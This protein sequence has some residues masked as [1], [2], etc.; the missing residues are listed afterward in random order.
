MPEFTASGLVRHGFGF[1]NPNHAAAL[2][3]ALAPFCWGWRGMWRWCGYAAFT[4]LCAALALTYSRAGMAVLAAE[5]AAWAVMKWRGSTRDKDGVLG[6]TRP[7]SHIAASALAVAAIVAAAWWMRSRIAV[8]GAVQNR[9]RIWLAGLRLFAANPLGVGFGYSGKIAS[10]FL[11][12]DGMTVRTLVNSHLTLLAETGVFVGGAW[13]VFVAA[14]I[15]A[16]W[17]RF[18]RVWLSFAGLAASA[19]LSSVFDWHVLFDFADMGGLSAMN[20]SLSWAMLGLFAVM[21]VWMIW[22]WLSARAGGAPAAPVCLSALSCV[23]ALTVSVFLFRAPETP[24]AAD[25]FAAV[26]DAYA[27]LMSYDSA[28]RRTSLSTTRGGT[29]W[30]ETSLLDGQ[31]VRAHGEDDTRQLRPRD[32]ID[33]DLRNPLRSW[34]LAKLWRK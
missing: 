9:P 1:Y 11:L 7:A 20:F 15:A 22:A 32:G 26:G 25:G 19:A 4:A 24:R 34:R 3:C 8:D 10:A 18:V 33:V 14:A 30:D 2:I 13:L 29:A 23:I 17:R 16:G 5:M 6:T 28:G 12:P 31:A 27:R 21:G